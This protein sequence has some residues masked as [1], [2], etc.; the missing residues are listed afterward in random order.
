MKIQFPVMMI[1]LLLTTLSSHWMCTQAYVS[2][3]APRSFVGFL[4]TMVGIGSPMCGFLMQMQQKSAEY[5][6]ILWIATGIAI[7]NVTYSVLNQFIS[8]KNKNK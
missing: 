2:I 6:S 8:V 5:Y 1:G 7:I 3:C 4:Y